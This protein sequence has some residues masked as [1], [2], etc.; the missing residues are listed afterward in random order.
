MADEAS[1]HHSYLA[2]LCRICGFLLKKDKFLVSKHNERLTKVFLENLKEDNPNKDPTHFCL[3]CYSKVKNIEERGSYSDSKLKSWS[4]HS[5]QCEVCTSVPSLLRGGR[6]KKVNNAG[7]RSAE[8]PIWDRKVSDT[9][10]NNT[11]DELDIDLKKESFEADINPQLSFCICNYCKNI[12]KR[13][14]L[15]SPCEHHLCLK[16]TIKNVE[17]KTLQNAKCPACNKNILPTNIHPSTKTV[18]LIKTLKLR[19]EKK[20]G[21]LF[22]FDEVLEK[23]HH[24]KS[25]ISSSSPSYFL[26]LS[27]LLEVNSSQ[28]ITKDMDNAVLHVIKTKLA[29]SENKSIE[30]QTGGPRVCMCLRGQVFMER[31]VILKTTLDKQTGQTNCT[32]FFH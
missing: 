17:G 22:K 18:E 8:H 29:D 23:K 2:K 28:E 7:R 21:L 4:V 31:N 3:K 14:V 13:P 1:V 26:P 10:I 9:I 25:C 5:T 16:C 11:P 15:I 30:F 12:M 24:E 27:S 6:K 32:N 19:C 20:C